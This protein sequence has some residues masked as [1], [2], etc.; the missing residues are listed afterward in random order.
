MLRK[1]T[2]AV[3]ALLM[4]AV[5]VSAAPTSVLAA[6]P[7]LRAA[8]SA[9]STTTSASVVVPA[10]VQAG[11]LL[12]LVVT[13]NTATTATTPSGW[14]LRGTQQDGT[15]DV[16]SWVFTGS[17]A[18]NTAG[19]TVAVTL[20]KSSK[21]ARTLVA[22]SGAGNP[23]AVVSSVMGASSTA[24]ATPATAVASADAV[25]LSYWADK[26]ASNS[27]W[28]L[29]GN[30]TSRST[31]IGAGS[32]RIT[33]AIGDSVVGAG[34][35]SGAT[36]NSTV[37]GTKGIAWTIVLP[38]TV[39]SI[40][41]TASFT[42]S[43]TQL[44]C[45]F[46]GTGSSDPDGTVT[47][48]AWNFGDG[49][50]GSGPTI[51]HTYAA[52]GS[53]NV[54]LT[55]TDNSGATGSVTTSVNVVVPVGGHT[56]LPPEVPRTDYPKITTGE[57]TD[58]EYIGNRVFIAGSFTSIA[59]NKSNNK[60]SY[61]QRYLAAYNLDTGLVDTA[62]RPTFDG[63]VTEIEASPDGTRLYAVGRFN[64]VNGVTK[65]KAVALN[66]T[67]GSVITAFTAN[68]NG[69]GTAVDATNSTVYIGG[70]FTTINNV[71]RVE[72]R[73]RRPRPAARW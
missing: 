23:A 55:V 25:V 33:A 57:I 47:S 27:G 38:G 36:A 68:L 32:G 10:S 3:L 9:N 65:R 28:T 18:A 61:T 56:A 71:S 70:Q 31:S 41:P 13:A 2:L 44:V 51:N 11:D 39:T 6:S 21:V 1:S 53:R 63:G 60:T 64:T 15:P 42:S 29:P 30:V 24:L 66:P 22:Y 40:A 59:N 5:F 54:Q 34:N 14:T 19:S 48:Y 20:G 62:F 16:T 50:T 8:V 37:A 7:A 45:S 58:L 49:A 73:R 69:A 46:D 43:C 72:P 35:W 26:S 67:N 4:S 12:V 52:A 17:A